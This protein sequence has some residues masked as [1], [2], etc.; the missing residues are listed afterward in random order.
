MMKYLLVILMVAVVA[1][2][3]EPTCATTPPQWFGQFREIGWNDKEPGKLIF[4]IANASYDRDAGKM[5]IMDIDDGFHEELTTEYFDYN[6]KMQYTVR[7]GECHHKALETPIPTFGVPSTAKYDFSEY[8][9][10][11]LP[12]LGVLVNEYSN[13]VADASIYGSSYAPVNADGSIC[14]PILTNDLTAKPG[15]MLSIIYYTNLTTTL[16]PGAL[17]KPSQCK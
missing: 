7:N 15:L 2:T 3:S 6:E 11:E 5:K 16:P 9:G 14:I 10:A 12:N 8:I 4:R 1:V 17:N 13:I